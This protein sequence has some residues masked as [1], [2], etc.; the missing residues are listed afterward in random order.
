[1][2]NSNSKIVSLGEIIKPHGIRGEVKILFFNDHSKS[3]KKDSVVLLGDST[4]NTKE[5]RVES[6]FY[7]N[8]K[9]RIKFFDINSIDEAERLR[10]LLINI[11]RENLPDLEKGEYYLNDLV[12][13]NL[14]DSSKYSYGV[15]VDV[16][17]LPA[18]DVLVIDYEKKEHLIPIIDDVI[19]KI[20]HKLK[21]I[22]I[23][24]IKGLFE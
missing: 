18:N 9:N 24:P 4:I 21:L 1:L 3:L 23:D 14:I 8:K 6:I 10:G 15:V 7:S 20:D 5:Y 2:S 19:L 17:H 12:D 11:Y 13:F 22:T 16:L